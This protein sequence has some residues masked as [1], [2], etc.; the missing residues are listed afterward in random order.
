MKIYRLT[1][2]IL[3]ALFAATGLLFLFAPGQVLA[4]FNSLST[5]FNMP[6][7]PETG[8]SFYLVLAVGYMYLVTFLA[9]L[10]YRHP[11]NRYFPQLLAHTKIASSLLSLALF[12][13]YQPYLIFLANFVVDGLIGAVVLVLYF[14]M[15]KSLR[16]VF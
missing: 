3:M 7:S 8:L 13:I 14:K 9:F 1:A 4:F 5:S 10:M 15:V 16:W 12:V 6:G 2:A 11:D